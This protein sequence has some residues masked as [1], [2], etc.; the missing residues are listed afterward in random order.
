[1]TENQVIEYNGRTLEVGQIVKH[2]KRELHATGTDYLYKIIGTAKHTETVLPFK[3][4]AIRCPKNKDGNT[5]AA[6]RYKADFPLHEFNVMEDDYVYCIGAV[7]CMDNVISAYNNS[8]DN[9]LDETDFYDSVL[10]KEV[11]GLSANPA[12]SEVYT[13]LVTNG[14]AELENIWN[15]A[16]KSADEDDINVEDSVY[17]D[18]DY[19]LL[20][21][22]NGVSIRYSTHP[23]MKYGTDD[24]I[25]VQKP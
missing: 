10:I 19:V 18:G 25:K 17:M 1:M 8:S 11:F 7:F 13:Y 24:V 3:I 16:L 23:I 2:F 12:A 15:A 22:N 6:W 4:E 9:S 14:A 21:Y 5:I 20:E